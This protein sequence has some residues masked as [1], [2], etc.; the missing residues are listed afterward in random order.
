MS[1]L[2]IHLCLDVALKRNFI[3]RG[4]KGSIDIFFNDQT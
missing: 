2:M 4:D 3:I 1:R